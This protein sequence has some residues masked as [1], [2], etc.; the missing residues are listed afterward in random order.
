MLLRAKNFLKGIKIVRKRKSIN[1]FNS[2]KGL[3]LRD[4]VI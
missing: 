2:Y 1:M 3:E 4:I